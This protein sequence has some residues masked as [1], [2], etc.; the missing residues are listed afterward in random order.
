M[1]TANITVTG[2]GL[3][4]EMDKTCKFPAQFY[5]RE[6]QNILKFQKKHLNLYPL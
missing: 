4:L 2:K 6:K 3:T 1:N 5:S